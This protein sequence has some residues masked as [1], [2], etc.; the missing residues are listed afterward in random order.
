MTTARRRAHLATALLLTLITLPV[1]LV[2]ATAP[3]SA[4]VPGTLCGGGGGGGGTPPSGPL[5]D[6]GDGGGGGGSTVPDTY[7][8]TVEFWYGAL[9]SP[10]V[11]KCVGACGAA[12]A[13][14]A[15]KFY[16][17][18]CT[19]SN[20]WGPW[21]GVQGT[22][23]GLRNHK[24]GKGHVAGHTWYSDAHFECISAAAWTEQDVT[25]V[26]SYNK[27]VAGPTGNPVVKHKV[28]QAKKNLTTA[29]TNSG[30]LS[31]TLCTMSY[32]VP[33]DRTLPAY[34]RYT[35]TVTPKFVHCTR[36]HYYKA[37]ALSQKIPP[38]R[39]G[40]C[41]KVDKA[42]PPVQAQT[43]V[44]CERPGWAPHWNGGHT[45]TTS[46]CLARPETGIWGCG[47]E[48]TYVPRLVGGDGVRR[49]A[50]PAQTLDNGT[51]TTLSWRR[52][53]P[54]G[55]VRDYQDKQ[56]RLRYTTG[57]PFR[58]DAAS[59]SATQPFVVNPTVDDWVFGWRALGEDGSTDFV[60]N[61]QAPSSTSG[62]PWT[63]APQW[64]FTAEFYMTTPHLDTVDVSTLAQA[65]TPEYKW[66]RLA[67]SCTGTAAQVSVFS[68]RQN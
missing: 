63:A 26:H 2:V 49:K 19:G 14:G 17:N 68:T 11:D 42:A 29:F 64:V 3:A 1:L 51:D 55:K 62:G 41:G 4:C 66:K 52:I 35:T 16:A 56:V 22:E 60:A 59:G 67:G 32:Q 33:I 24:P 30:S 50:D 8:S 10:P 43:Q 25:C 20:K 31:P 7:F 15:S 27:T 47:P 44:F 53:S 39:I 37:V 57:T 21:Y 6:D 18:K 45:Y 46:D 34:G 12:K 23:A 40:N 61:F 58:S 36:Y 48:A 28:L 13:S 9:S 38:D 54:E 5:D 65:V